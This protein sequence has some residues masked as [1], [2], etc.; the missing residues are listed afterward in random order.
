MKFA[1]VLGLALTAPAAAA[2]TDWRVEPAMAGVQYGGPIPDNGEMMV[3][4]WRNDGGEYV[5]DK[6]FALAT[7]SNAGRIAL[8][9]EKFRYRDANGSAAWTIAKFLSFPGLREKFGANFECGRGAGFSEPV[10]DT[11]TYVGIVEYAKAPAQDVF[12]DGIVA[13]AKVDLKTG[14]INPVPSND[15]YCIQTLDD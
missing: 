5:D 6:Y 13:A 1:F 11:E 15:I 14:A 2:I 3:Q 10:S 8:S 9:V 7:Y 4:G 12:H